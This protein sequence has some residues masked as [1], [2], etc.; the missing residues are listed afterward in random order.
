MAYLK[1][2]VD[3]VIDEHDA[4]HGKA[5]AWGGSFQLPWEFRIT[6]PSGAAEAQRQSLAPSPT[7]IIKGNVNREGVR[8]YHMPN[9]PFYTRTNPENWFCTIDEAERAGFR[10]AGRP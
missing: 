9:D 6:R 10:R 5:G 3:Y 8:I 7:C 1:Y 4:E 2:S